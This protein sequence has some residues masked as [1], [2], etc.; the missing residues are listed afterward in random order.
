MKNIIL[1][2]VALAIIAALHIG[3]V[4]NTLNFTH[5]F[6]RVNATL[7]GSLGGVVLAMVLLRICALLPKAR[8]WLALLFGFGLIAS[9]A[10][11]FYSANVFI[12]AEVYIGWA[13]NAWHKAAYASFASFVPAF[14]LLANWRLGKSG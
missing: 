11:V 7:Y 10:T 5:P 8:R 14:V 6:W 2:A 4:L 9:I 1:I 12:N 3:G 13:A